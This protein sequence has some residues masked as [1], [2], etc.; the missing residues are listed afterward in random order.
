MRKVD[1]SFFSGTFGGECLSLAAAIAT[2]KMMGEENAVAKTK[3]FGASLAKELSSLIQQKSLSD[4]GEVSGPD[5]WP[6][7][8]VRATDR[9]S[10]QTMTSLLR[11]ELVAE[12]L[13]LCATFNL[14]LAHT[15]GGVLD[16][17]GDRWARSRNSIRHHLESAD[18]KKAL[19]GP[20]IEPV[21]KVRSNA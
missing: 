4:Y 9:V 2:I 10:E 8:Q 5:W 6:A 14:S 16:T 15:Q 18:P 3:A 11:Q 20:P 1:D 12:G 7:I 17:I 19:L 13:L 21:F